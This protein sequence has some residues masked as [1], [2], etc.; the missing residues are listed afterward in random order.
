MLKWKRVQFFDSQCII[1]TTSWLQYRVVHQFKTVTKQRSSAEVYTPLSAFYSTVL[2]TQHQW[3][4]DSLIQHTAARH[5]WS[6]SDRQTV[7]V[8]GRYML[9]AI[10]S[11]I[12]GTNADTS[13]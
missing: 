6:V 2:K 10:V 13:V 7:D 12:H 1:P 11:S 8:G 5:E 4:Q 3:K 9:A